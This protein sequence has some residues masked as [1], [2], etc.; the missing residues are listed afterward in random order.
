M[1]GS[2]STVGSDIF[3]IGKITSTQVLHNIII[4]FGCA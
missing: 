2:I 1:E 3:F 4:I